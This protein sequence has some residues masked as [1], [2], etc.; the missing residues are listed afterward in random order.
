[1]IRSKS[2]LVMVVIFLG[3][4]AE[5][6]TATVTE[7]EPFMV[8]IA[9]NGAIYIGAG[10]DLYAMSPEENFVIRT[11][12]IASP[13]SGGITFKPRIIVGGDVV[14]GP[15]GDTAVAVEEGARSNYRGFCLCS[16]DI[17]QFPNDSPSDSV[18]R[19]LGNRPRRCEH[20]DNNICH[21]W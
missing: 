8:G 9:A 4:C 13:P 11:N 2:V 14:I 6:S 19:L 18:F 20:H 3:L 16:Y 5:L 7:I 17:P 1:M 15:G 21:C 10:C 12:S